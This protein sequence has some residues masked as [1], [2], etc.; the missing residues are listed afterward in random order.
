[1]VHQWWKQFM[2]RVW[3][4]P[5]CFSVPGASIL[6]NSSLKTW[7]SHW[8]SSQKL[9]VSHLPISLTRIILHSWSNSRAIHGN[10]NWSCSIQKAF[11]KINGTVRF[12]VYFYKHL[13]F[14]LFS[15]NVP[16]ITWHLSVDTSLC[17]S[18]LV[19]E[20]N[21]MTGCKLF[22]RKEHWFQSHRLSSP[23]PASAIR[24]HHLWSLA[25][26]GVYSKPQWE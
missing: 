23:D 20:D 25:N 14:S 5:A 18:K 13:V 16:R 17:H 24:S 6:V 26:H 22:D 19:C 2:L 11:Y 12:A 21:G 1:M 4:I 8:C 9:P 10:N 7:L 3:I 15:L